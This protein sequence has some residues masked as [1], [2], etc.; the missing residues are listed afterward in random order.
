MRDAKERILQTD[1][2]I[3]SIRLGHPATYRDSKH[4][5]CFINAD[6]RRRTVIAL[7]IELG[8]IRRVLLYSHSKSPLASRLQHG[9]DLSV[10]SAC[11][12]QHNIVHPFLGPD[13]AS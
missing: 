11:S 7:V 9:Q 6:N 13:L 2:S 4:M 8:V 12:K 1:W 5:P 10:A 3:M